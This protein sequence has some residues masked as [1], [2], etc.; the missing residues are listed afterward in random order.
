MVCWP[1]IGDHHINSRFVGQV[2]KI[3]L[4]MKDTCDREIIEKMVNDLMANEGEKL[5]KSMDSVS[6]MSKKTVSE[7]GS[8][9]RNLVALIECIKNQEIST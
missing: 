4:D 1:N 3:G 7:D 9:H 8:S 6:D 5:R 2:W